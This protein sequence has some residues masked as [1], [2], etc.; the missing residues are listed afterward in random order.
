MVHTNIQS[1]SAQLVF[2]HNQIRNICH[3]A[4]QKA[5]KNQKA[6]PN[7]QGEYT[8]KTKI[9]KSTCIN[10]ETRADKNCMEN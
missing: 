4:D 10:K 1:M 3:N 5:G 8:Q 9:A 7:Q 2:G 6:S